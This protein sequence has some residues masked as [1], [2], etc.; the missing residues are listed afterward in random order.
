[1]ATMPDTSSYFGTD[2]SSSV[3]ASWNDGTAT[4]TT[5]TCWNYWI[6]NGAGTS[7]TSANVWAIWN[8]DVSTVTVV[9]TNIVNNY[10]Q[11]VP[12]RVAS[13]E[14]I[15]AERERIRVLREVNERLLNEQREKEAIAVKRAEDLLHSYL[16]EANSERYRKER[17]IEVWSQSGRRF[18]IRA[19]RAH[20]IHELSLE[21]TA[22]REFCIHVRD[23][24]PN[25][26]NVLAQ[27]L[28]IEHREADFLQIANMKQLVA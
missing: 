20:N 22:I 25:P 24:V 18:R 13:P 7:S 8:A 14:E 15:E 10:S 26:D 5:D 9:R 6:Q 27:K 11:P 2:T 12:C 23:N 19:G 21:G 1:M 16:D 4:S 28:M 3:W 17:Y